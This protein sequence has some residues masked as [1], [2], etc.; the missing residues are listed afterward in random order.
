MKKIRKIILTAAILSLFLN[1]CGSGED[2]F[3]KSH[4]AKQNTEFTPSLDTEAEITLYALGS[5]SNFEALEEVA[6][7]F[8]EYYPNVLIR[9][10]MQEDSS[11]LQNRLIT[12]EE[13]D[14]Y[15]MLNTYGSDT[16]L[17]V[18]KA[19][20]LEEAGIDFSN[21]PENVKKN[22]YIA[23]ELKGLPIMQ[24]VNGYMVN[25][26]LLSKYGLSIPTKQEEFMA[27][28][29]TLKE[30]GITPIMGHP[31]TVYKP[32][33]N[34]LLM[35]IVS[36]DNSEEIIAS[37]SEGEDRFGIVKKNLEEAF[38]LKEKGYISEEGADLEDAY[39][40][41]IMRFLKGDV[42]FMACTAEDFSG[43]KKR[44]AKSEAFEENPF[45]Y[46]FIPSPTGEEGFEAC[47]L[48]DIVFC[49]Y[50]NSPT[51]DY[52][53]EFFRFLS[54]KKELNTIGCTKGM[55]TVTEDSGDPRFAVLEDL[56][57]AEKL[58]LSETDIDYQIIIAYQ[59]ACQALGNNAKDIDEAV[60]AF[61][62]AMKK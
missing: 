55:P 19:V 62:Q 48:G 24:S 50:E 51:V 4:T 13:L 6:K 39:N 49:A 41:V 60:D 21:M 15:L 36:A 61:R 22:G 5:W 32:S 27:V 31:N 44:E 10:T 29:D 11:V 59:G 25:T 58:Y 12:G 17:S 16:A 57:D 45:D 40:A 28:C 46:Q 38:L 2:L 56:S 35:D 20:N 33:V 42:P 53:L 1:G 34:G 30:N 14:F 52:T 9:Y 54:T 23:G 47:Y 43:V 7:D 8:N 3:P 37:L 18:E 26:S